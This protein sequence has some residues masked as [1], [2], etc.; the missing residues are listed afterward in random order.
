MLTRTRAMRPTAARA[1]R[2]RTRRDGSVE[3]VD[4]GGG[5]RGPVEPDQ[6]GGRAAA[7]GQV[8]EGR[9]AV[10]G[11]GV[12]VLQLELDVVDDGGVEPRG[13]ALP[14]LRG[15]GLVVIGVGK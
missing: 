5:A 7:E 10:E 9:R 14:S 15:S 11:R 2:S 4:A 1:R 6:R 8:G 3:R 13:S 12:E